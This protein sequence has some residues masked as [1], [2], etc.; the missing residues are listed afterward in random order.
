MR[1]ALALLADMALAHPDGKVYILGGGIDMLFTPTV[2]FQSQPFSLA[3]K[4]EFASVETDRPHTIEVHLLDPDGHAVMPAMKN[5]VV[6]RRHAQWPT[7]MSGAVMVLGFIGIQF[8]QYGSY[9][10]SILVDG[11]E[12]TSLPLFIE[13]PPAGVPTIQPPALQA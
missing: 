11:N 6:P 1:V 3:L 13:R 5:V 9:A 12:Q 2:P 7:R 8:Q 4:I 10:F